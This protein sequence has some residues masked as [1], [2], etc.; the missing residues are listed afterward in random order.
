MIEINSREKSKYFFLVHSEINNFRWN[1]GRVEYW[2][3]RNNGTM[4]NGMIGY[5]IHR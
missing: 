3:E 5:W 2:E 4:D 1:N